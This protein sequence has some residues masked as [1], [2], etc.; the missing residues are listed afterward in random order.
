MA[1]GGPLHGS[2]ISQISELKTQICILKNLEAMGLN[3]Y[4]KMQYLGL[5]ITAVVVVVVVVVM[6]EA[7]AVAVV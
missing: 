3:L 4:T 7:A 2:Q 1:T 6:L 5:C